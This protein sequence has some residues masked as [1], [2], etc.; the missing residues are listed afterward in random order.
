MTPAD[1][2][3]ISPTAHYTAFV[4][5]RYGLSHPALVTPLGRRLYW[6]L[7]PANALLD[8][9]GR[10]QLEGMLLARHGAIDRL[11]ADAIARGTVSQVVELA[12]G[13]SPRGIRF[14]RQHPGL[15]YLETDLPRQAE[16]KRRLLDEA[17]LR[18]PGHEVV[19]LDALRD[20]GPD[21][22]DDV[23]ARHL[24]PKAGTVLITE[25]LLNYF[26]AAT[27]DAMW[28]RFARA[29]SRFPHGLYLSDLNLEGD[30]D[31]VLAARVFRP[32]LGWFA[33]GQIHLHHRDPASAEAALTAAGFRRAEI[34]TPTDVDPS[35]PRASS[36]LV[37][38]VEA[39]TS[40]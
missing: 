32:L 3:R 21:S 18:A 12:A 5:H 29:L 13:F 24:D 10:A 15:R 11:I 28:R 36:A 7:R 19:A 25:G 4:W 6:A 23:C 16:A 20:D 35:L 9:L 31:R 22:L 38:I 14:M 26:E 30:L 27:V 34:F 17:G 8:K 1:G 40:H 33:R 2:A 39:S 37:R